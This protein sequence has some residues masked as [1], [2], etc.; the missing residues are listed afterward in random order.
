MLQS[1]NIFNSIS[2]KAA[3]I[4]PSTQLHAALISCKQNT[5]A[6]KIQTGQQLTTFIPAYSSPYSNVQEKLLEIQEIIASLIREKYLLGQILMATIPFGATMMWTP[7]ELPLRSSFLTIF[8]LTIV[9]MLLQP[10]PA[11]P[12]KAGQ[13]SPSALSK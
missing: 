1:W 10:L 12:P 7:G 8:L 11:T 2:N 6:V 3:V 13:T 4:I 5:V 9:R